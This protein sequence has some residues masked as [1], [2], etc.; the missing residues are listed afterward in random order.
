MSAR[1]AMSGEQALAVN[2][3]AKQVC[4]VRVPGRGSLA[5]SRS[6]ALEVSAGVERWTASKVQHAQCAVVQQCSQ[7]RQRRSPRCVLVAMGGTGSPDAQCLPN[8][9]LAHASALRGAGQTETMR[10]CAVAD[11]V[12]RMQT[13]RCSY[14]DYKAIGA[15]SGATRSSPVWTP[16]R[17]THRP[18][19]HAGENK[20]SWRAL[21][22][23]AM[24]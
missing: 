21:G 12:L 6:R 11:C 22:N 7:L 4:L 16:K 3:V 17:E 9:R 20:E 23:C 24:Q 18:R 13:A 14:N 15:R 5:S 19:G 8:K 10:G 2:S 1:V